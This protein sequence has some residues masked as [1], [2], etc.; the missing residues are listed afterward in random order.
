MVTGRPSAATNARRTQTSSAPLV[1]ATMPATAAS[2][3]AA[4]VQGKR[5][6]TS[7]A[8][9]A[10]DAREGKRMVAPSYPELPHESP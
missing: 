1:L 10:S 3:P 8:R 7:A 9:S 2:A 5:R 6:R 4:S